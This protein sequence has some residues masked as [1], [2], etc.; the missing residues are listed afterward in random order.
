M[1]SLAAALFRAVGRDSFGRVLLMD[2]NIAHFIARGV[3]ARSKVKRA[4]R[5]RRAAVY[6]ILQKS[7]VYPP[8]AAPL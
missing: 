2:D 1:A 5:A 8:R 4:G 7:G 3:T 6:C